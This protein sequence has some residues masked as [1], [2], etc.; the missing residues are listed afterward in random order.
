MLACQELEQGNCGFR[1]RIVA[2]DTEA[3]TSRV[4]LDHA[5]APMGAATVALPLGDSV[6]LGTFAGDRIARVDAAILGGSDQH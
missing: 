4:L 3:M 1:F 5:G 2:I 6:W